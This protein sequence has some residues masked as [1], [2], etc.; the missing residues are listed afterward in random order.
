[1]STVDKKPGTDLTLS[2]VIVSYNVRDFLGQALTSIQ[3]ALLGI[4]HE[5]FVVDNASTDGTVEYLEKRHPEVTL[6]ANS[7]NV[8]FGRANNQAIARSQG[9][10]ICVINP[11]TIVQEDTFTVLLEFFEK[12]PEAGAIGSKILNPDGT[13]QLACRRSFPT[14]WVA[15]TK[16]AGLASLFPHSR[17]FGRYNLTYLDPEQVAEVEAIS[18]SFMLV[19]K[20]VIDAVGGFDEAFFMYGEDLDWCYRIRNG[21]WKI[22]YVPHTQIVHFKGESSKKSPFAQRRLFYEAM[23]L[24]VNKHFSGKNAL[25]PSWF[26]VLAIKAR[27]LL[28]FLSGVGKHLVLPG[29]DVVCVTLSMA[30]AIFIRF[31]P[32]FPWK[33]FVLVNIVYSIVWLAS[34]TGYGLYSRNKFSGTKSIAA[35]ALGMIINSALTFFFKQYGFSR[36]V[37]LY[38]GLINFV[39]IP[40]WRALL[41]RVMVKPFKSGIWQ[42]RS[43]IVGDVKTSAELVNRIRAHL[44]ESYKLVGV[45]LNSGKLLQE[46]ISGLPVLGTMQHLAEIIRREK[47]QEVIFATDKIAYDQML[48]VIAG[49]NDSGVTFKMVPSNLDVII[50]KAS[51]DYIQDIPFVDLEYK[52][53]ST[54]H[55]TLKRVFDIIVAA[56]LLVV[57]A[58]VYAWLKWVKRYPVQS[59]QI[60]GAGKR[61]VVLQEF[62]TPELKSIWRHIPWLFAVL[63]G[64]ISFV[65]R[66]IVADLSNRD[67][68]A[69]LSLKPGITGLEQLNRSRQIDDAE[70]IKYNIYYL[71]NYSLLLD[72]QIVIKSVFTKNKN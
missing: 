59:K 19:R 14:P 71:K 40:G 18:G 68:D 61:Y 53:H 60:K 41:K 11:D 57:I 20:T 22:Y 8:G 55:R 26:L 33:P 62:M 28:A 29:I 2:I 51:I 23:R 37:I 7:E 39:I 42:Q 44:H 43:V 54:L 16:I 36:A 32:A 56:L 5:I 21:G 47:I 27:A 63:R 4:S 52:L 64:D 6:I 17:L 25:F 49:S 15:F 48:A 34:L 66:E 1:M 67:K 65:G 50:G 24:F 13:L 10:Y 12:H 3:K 9:A 58:P 31:H 38:S 30:A 70:R 46:E 69:G 45:V 35:V 72:L